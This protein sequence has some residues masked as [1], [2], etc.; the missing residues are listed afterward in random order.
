MSDVL[1]LAYQQRKDFQM[2][3]RIVHVL[4]GVNFEDQPW[5][6]GP[7]MTPSGF[8]LLRPPDH[9]LA[10]SPQRLDSC[11]KDAA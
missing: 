6:F 5:E 7:I 10:H 8:E 11:N 4:V 3:E 1:M 9:A 2:G